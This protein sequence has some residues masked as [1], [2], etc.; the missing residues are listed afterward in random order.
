M[1]KYPNDI[2]KLKK[3]FQTNTHSYMRI[4]PLTM[5]WNL[6]MKGLQLKQS[7]TQ[8]RGSIHSIRLHSTHSN[9]KSLTLFPFSK[10]LTLFPKSN[11]L[12]I[13]IYR[14]SYSSLRFHLHKWMGLHRRHKYPCAPPPF[15]STATIIPP[16]YWRMKNGPWPID[17]KLFPSHEHGILVGYQVAKVYALLILPDYC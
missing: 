4:Y 17:S 7:P 1:Y 8:D 10:S 3:K 11:H 14:L 16:T 2:Y 15:S 9:S 13:T 5:A 6:W 12:K